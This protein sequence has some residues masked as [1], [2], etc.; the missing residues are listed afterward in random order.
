M[1]D[2]PL[3]TMVSGIPQAGQRHRGGMNCFGCHLT[4]TTSV[5]NVFPALKALF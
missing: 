5:S 4:N 1:A 2:D 3:K